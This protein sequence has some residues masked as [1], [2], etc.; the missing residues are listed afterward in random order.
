LIRDDTS[1]PIAR[2]TNLPMI[3]PDTPIVTQG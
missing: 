2:Y 3:D 1:T